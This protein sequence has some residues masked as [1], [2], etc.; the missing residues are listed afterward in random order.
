MLKK[1][2]RLINDAVRTMAKGYCDSVDEGWVV[3]FSEPS[4]T[5]DQNADQWP[6]LDAFS[7]GLVWTVNGQ[8]C[9]LSPD[10]WKD[11]LTAAFMGETVR[12]APG[13]NGGMVVLGARTSKFSKRQFSEWLEFLHAEAASRG[14]EPVYK[15]IGR[16]WE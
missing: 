9:R 8:P 7:K 2:L 13:L 11:I 10:E 1:T 3:T 14:I 5:L 4:R 15:N 16:G 6:Y 12:I